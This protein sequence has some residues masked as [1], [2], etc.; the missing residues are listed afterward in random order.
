MAEETIKRIGDYEVLAEIGGGAQGKIFKARCVSDSNAAVRQGE[1]V[2]LKVVRRF[3]DDD[4]SE[5]RF[6]REVRIFLK[7]KHPNLVEYKETFTVRD[8]WA[9]DI[10]CLVMEYLEGEDLG[11]RLKDHPGGLPFET[12]KPIFTQALEGLVCARE[13]GII[14]R[15]LKPANIFLLSDGRVK[16][17]D[18]GIAR[19][20]DGTVTTTA[21]FK[22]TYD[23]MAPDFLTAGEDF[24][25]DE[26]SDIFSLGVCFYRAL[27][28]RLPYP[29]SKESGWVAYLNRWPRGKLK[30][31]AL[32]SG[33]L[34][35]LNDRALAFLRTALRA[36]RNE[37]YS[38]FKAMLADLEGIE[39][40][41][42]EVGK[43]AYE[44]LSYL[45]K[46]GFGEVFKA[47][48]VEDGKLFAIK[49]LFP[50]LDASRFEREA[51]LL[52][53]YPH[54]NIV[55]Y[56]DAVTLRQIDGEDH[57]LIL[58]FLDGMPGLGLRS[59]IK[60]EGAL[61]VAEV[62]RLFDA[63]LAALDFLHTVQRKPILH[64]DIT[65]ANL[66]APPPGP[67]ADESLIPKL[68]DMGIARSEQTLTGG[69]VPGNPEYMAPEFVTEP[70]FRGSVRSD[71]YCVGLCLY[72]ALT[73]RPAFERL[74]K[75]TAEMWQGLKARASGDAAI[76]YDHSVFREQPAVEQLV[77]K[78]IA[79]DPAKRFGSA[80]EM[81][82]AVAT[83]GKADSVS[84][85]SP[86]PAD[87]AATLFVPQPEVARAV[88]GMRRERGRRLALGAAAAAAALLLALGIGLL[89][90]RDPE[91]RAVRRAQSAA[92][93][94]LTFEPTA[95]YVGRLRQGVEENR[96][97]EARF[98]RQP[99]LTA[100]GER[101]VAQWD[102]LSR[103]FEA[104]FR[105]ALAR[106]DDAAAET[107]LNEWKA[108]ETHLPFA[109][110][111]A[112]EH[113]AQTLSMET[114]LAF[115]RDLAR[116]RAE[117]AARRPAAAQGLAELAQRARR[118]GEQA[119][120]EPVRDWWTDMRRALAN[121]AAPIPQAVA[122]AFAEAMRNEQFAEAE[123]VARQWTAALEADAEDELWPSAALDA[124]RQ[125]MAD[126][127]ARTVQRR[128]DAAVAA[129][130]ADRPDAADPLFVWLR[131][132]AD[133]APALAGWI[134][135]V[136]PVALEDVERA[137]QAAWR[138]ALERLP[139]ETEAANLEEYRRQ[140]A[141]LAELYE[142]W[143]A[144]V[145]PEEATRMRQ[146]VADA[147]VRQARRHADR[148]VQAYNAS[149][150]ERGQAAQDMV[151]RL[152]DAVPEPFRDESLASLPAMAARA[153]DQSRR[154][155][156]Q[157]ARAEAD[158]TALRN[159]LAVRHPGEWA[160]PLKDWKGLALPADT[161]ATL[162]RGETWQALVA[163]MDERIAVA[164]SDADRSASVR[165]LTDLLA[166]AETG[167]LLGDVRLGR[168]SARLNAQ[169]AVVDTLARLTRIRAAIRPEDPDGWGQSFRDLAECGTPEAF[170]RRDVNEAWRATE[171]A[172][173]AQVQQYV[174]RPTTA[175]RERN[176]RMARADS[177]LKTVRAAGVFDAE[178]VLA[179]E[180]AIAERK[181][182][183]TKPVRPPPTAYDDPEADPD[184]PTPPPVAPKPVAVALEPERPVAPKPAQTQPLKPLRTDVV[185]LLE[186][187]EALL[188]QRQ[189]R[190][191]AKEMSEE[192]PRRL[193]D[194]A[195]KAP[196]EPDTW[197]AV[198]EW[199]RDRRETY[200]VLDLA[201]RDGLDRFDR[202]LGEARAG[203]LPARW[204]E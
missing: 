190:A 180:T 143:H 14:H 149:E 137:R 176:A 172:L 189:T 81:R 85:A 105:D 40:R 6:E 146:A 183:P 39:R 7:L 155:D 35:V 186:P 185:R 88:A 21:G 133:S 54:P 171:M 100:L 107:A 27:T 98:P 64:R 134:G 159:A 174:A 82:A 145:A 158:L 200:P 84:S 151:K 169:R 109:G 51:R 192:L 70:D 22:G 106:D 67:T 128:R 157:F 166:L 161:R 74:S 95:D 33:A 41:R 62:R 167:A 72:E 75:Q 52:R 32:P 173:F 56:E 141:T 195:A 61:D 90:R 182:A 91:T 9:A 162:A 42:I 193:R 187:I 142:R 69:H 3:G 96:A 65:P 115:A 188:R 76:S 38:S 4:K 86:E 178:S 58:E 201:D 184:E 97:L 30:D 163:V 44:F 18:F 113:R 110:L 48:R 15:D 17:I 87:E 144:A 121:D 55:A 103:N 60:R 202:E 127:T 53:K 63:W 104:A 136:L 8:E 126:E 37:R 181:R 165:A 19:K 29:G 123:T 77:R 138:R 16:V 23:Y 170:A 132:F 26:Q 73:G 36:N 119:A 71:L 102:L 83:L 129:Y 147:C 43:T 94:L 124:A 130:A 2:A 116:Q 177:L 80:A 46:G 24:R 168:L 114:R 148:A 59:R 10:H 49:R 196:L 197:E 5:E 179:L 108:A 112:F 122:A 28:G 140:L 125:A 89:V 111:T 118:M 57:Y 13:N 120:S 152:A 160:D 34:R 79:C 175:V 66:Y 191:A 204:S 1:T 198:R 194:L 93:R 31:M 156:E 135:D 47:R 78:A 12:I 154:K 11:V 150:Y 117:L 153:H 25:G 50:G 92:D 20:E 99:D 45:G 101:M 68:F 203:A 164:I 131:G 139:R 199:L